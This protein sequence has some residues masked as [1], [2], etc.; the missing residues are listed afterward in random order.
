MHIT[1]NVSNFKQRGTS[2]R[3]IR[4]KSELRI[5]NSEQVKPYG[6]VLAI[7]KYLTSKKLLICESKVWK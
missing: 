3:P 4:K 7:M 5:E 1:F 6:K 2:D